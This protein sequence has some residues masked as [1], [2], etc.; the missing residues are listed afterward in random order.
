MLY[1]AIALFGFSVA[2]P[3][4]AAITGWVWDQ[5]TAALGRTW[6]RVIK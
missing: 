1:A 4:A 2:V 6:K 3:L 5:W